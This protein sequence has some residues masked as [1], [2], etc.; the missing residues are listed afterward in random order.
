MNVLTD[1]NILYGKNVRLTGLRAGDVDA[2]GR[3]QEDAGFWRM[4]STSPSRPRT[5]EANAKYLQDLSERSDAFAFVIRPIADDH[6][7]GLIS[8]EQV[9]WTHGVANSA[10]VS[11]GPTGAKGTGPKRSISCCD[12]ASTN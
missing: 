2:V 9:L 12:S 6:Y 3:Q 11:C 7:V 8:L 4:L 5:T 1:E 10:W